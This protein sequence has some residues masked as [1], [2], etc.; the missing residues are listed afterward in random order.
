LKGR[1]L[2]LELGAETE[3]GL[4]ARIDGGSVYEVEKELLAQ[5][6]ELA[7]GPAAPQEAAPA[8]EEDEFGH[9]EDHHGHHLH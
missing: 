2:K 6:R 9:A 3:S 1:E 4:R 8:P 7:G 5:V